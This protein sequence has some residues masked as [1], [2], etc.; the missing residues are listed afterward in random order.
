MEISIAWIMKIVAEEV[1]KHQ[2]AT[3]CTD[4]EVG[5]LA[6]ACFDEAVELCT[7]RSL[8]PA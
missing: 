6:L 2:A 4:K 8:I 3:G 5:E 7:A 1:A